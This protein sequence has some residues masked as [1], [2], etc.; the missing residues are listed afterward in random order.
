M[1]LQLMI[2]SLAAGLALSPLCQAAAS[3]AATFSSDVSEDAYA[4]SSSDSNQSLLA[5]YCK[6]LGDAIRTAGVD[7]KF[8]D[9]LKAQINRL[10]FAIQQPTRDALDAAQDALSG[11]TLDAA[12]GIFV[13]LSDAGE[14][15][16]MAYRYAWWLQNPAEEN[17][18]PVVNLSEVFTE[19]TERNKLNFAPFHGLSEA[20]QLTQL[21]IDLV[22]CKA[23]QKLLRLAS[24][25]V[26]SHQI[27]ITSAHLTILLANQNPGL[28]TLDLSNCPALTYLSAFNNQSLTALDLSNNHALTFLNVDNNP[29]LTDFRIA[30]RTRIYTAEIAHINAIV[31]ANRARL[32]LPLTD[33][34]HAAAGADDDAEDDE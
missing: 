25:P 2:L 27:T 32:A 33:A 31:E 28:T 21:L 29:A 6:E 15:I 18:D 11:Q 30:P 34:G 7:Q 17:L 20:N 14:L 26:D 8:I 13:E 19:F 24:I 5:R 22:L 23:D 3:S 4:A 10:I 12:K 16:K 1:K 9:G